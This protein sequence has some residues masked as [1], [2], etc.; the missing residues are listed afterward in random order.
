MLAPAGGRYYLAGEIE[1]LGCTMY[2]YPTAIS[3]IRLNVVEVGSDRIV[4]SKGFFARRQAHSFRHGYGD[5]VLVLRDLVSR[6]L[7]DTVDSALDDREIRR[8]IQ[9]HEP[10]WPRGRTRPVTLPDS[11]NNRAS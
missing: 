11:L 10:R 1:E 6:A 9:Q 2:S 3:R 4:F 7:Q 8:A 5:P